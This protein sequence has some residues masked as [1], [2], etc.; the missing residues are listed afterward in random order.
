[1]M[2]GLRKLHWATRPNKQKVT[3]VPV[4][5]TSPTGTPFLHAMCPST[6]KIANPAKKL[7]LQFPMVMTRVSLEPEMPWLKRRKPS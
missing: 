6:E 4:S 3:A 7:V 2:P 1:M 5:A